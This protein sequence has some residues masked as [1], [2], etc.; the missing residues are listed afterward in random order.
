MITYK[1]EKCGG[2]MVISPSGDLYCA[3]CGTKSNFSDAQLREYKEFRNHMLQYLAAVANKKLDANRELFLWGYA[4]KAY[5]KTSDGE[6]VVI[7]YLFKTDDDGITMYMAK[8]SVIYVFPGNRAKDADAM[9]SNIASV[10]YPSADMKGLSRLVPSLKARL[11]LEGGAVLLAFIKEPNMYPL[12]AFGSLEYAHSAWILS[13]LENLCCVLEYSDLVHGGFDL[14]AVYINPY[15]HEAA[16]YGGWWKTK[17]KTTGDTTDL[18]DIR[19][20]VLRVLGIKKDSSP[21]P[22][23]EFLNSAPAEDAYKDFEAWDYTLENKL[24]GRHFAKFKM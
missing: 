22:F 11:E 1:C 17:R 14:G 3:Y 13:R 18:K 4:E 15:S 2:E 24:G 19:K 21:K 16:L 20:L 8:D 9:L 6:D 5:Y 23:L 12:E 7:E 10:K